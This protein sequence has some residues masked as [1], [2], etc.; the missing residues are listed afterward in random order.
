[1]SALGNRGRPIPI[2]EPEVLAAGAA[3]Y[4]GDDDKV[5]TTALGEVWWRRITVASRYRKAHEIERMLEM[6]QAVPEALLEAILSIYCDSKAGADCTVERGCMPPAMR[7]L[8]HRLGTV[9][10]G[11]NGIKINSRDRLRFDWARTGLTMADARKVARERARGG[12]DEDRG[13]QLPPI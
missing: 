12:S 3:K 7:D 2:H 9:S 11:H 13:Q 6:L 1:M 10:R 4:R 5:A 8:A